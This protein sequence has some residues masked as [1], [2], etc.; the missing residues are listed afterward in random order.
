LILHVYVFWFCMN[1]HFVIILCAK[2]L[3]FS[4]SKHSFHH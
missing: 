1:I 4:S 2:T 3:Q